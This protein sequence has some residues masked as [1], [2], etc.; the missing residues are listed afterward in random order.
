[1]KKILF[2]DDLR[3]PDKIINEKSD[4]GVWIYHVK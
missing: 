4:N 3:A 2:L 1:M